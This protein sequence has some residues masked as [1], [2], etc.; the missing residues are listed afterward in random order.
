MIV[1]GAGGGMGRAVALRAGIEG[2]R[3]MAADY[4]EQGLHELVA[5][6]RAAGGEADQCC[7]DITQSYF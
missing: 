2:A 7:S 1:T 5:E 4:T 3:V 6:I